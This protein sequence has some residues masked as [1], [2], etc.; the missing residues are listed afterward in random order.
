MNRVHFIPNVP[1]QL[2]LLTPNEQQA[3]DAPDQWVYFLKDGRVLYAT[4]ELAC[5]INILEL[6]PGESFCVCKR[7]NGERRQA[8]RWEAWRAAERQIPAFQEP[9]ACDLEQQLRASLEARRR[10]NGSWQHT[11]TRRAIFPAPPPSNPQ[12]VPQYDA[13]E[14]LRTPAV[15][16]PWS[17]ALLLQTNALTDVFAGALTHASQ[18]GISVKPE[19]VRSLLITAYIAMNKGV[20]HA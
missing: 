13:A 6:A 4:S 12:P 14:P 9:D 17:D 10:K 19:D 18:H 8:A 15:T 16:S 20:Y 3:P 11:K 5:Q 2:S 7:W 1:Q